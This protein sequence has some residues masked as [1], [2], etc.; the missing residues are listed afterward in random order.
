MIDNNGTPQEEV[1]KTEAKVEETKPEVK[2][3]RTRTPA[4]KATVANQVVKPTST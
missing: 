3:T 1:S 2:P 4:A